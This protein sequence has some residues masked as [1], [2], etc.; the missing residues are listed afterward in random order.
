MKFTEY[1]VTRFALP[2]G[3]YAEVIVDEEGTSFWMGH[4]DYGVKEM[5]F[6]VSTELMPRE[7][8]ETM[9]KDNCEEY[10]EDFREAWMDD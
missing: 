5:M 9:L 7:R 1:S 8:W 2:D 10:M 4:K 3:F 6:G